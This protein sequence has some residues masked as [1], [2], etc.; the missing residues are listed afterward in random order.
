MANE[1]IALGTDIV[2]TERISAAFKK[3]GKV[4]L[5]KIFTGDEIAYCMQSTNPANGLAA[6]F[7]AK[8][9]FSK[10]LGTGFGKNLCW[11]DVSVG[12]KTS[13]EPH[14]VLSE[15]GKI[16]MKNLGFSQIKISIAHT[17]TLAHAVVLLIK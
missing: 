11:K 10:A 7:A 5:G 13:G 3:F 2:D 6:R 1:K 14:I 4:F 8:E 15:R 16:L 9:A 12:K 17:K